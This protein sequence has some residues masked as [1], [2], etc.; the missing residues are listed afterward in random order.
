MWEIKRIQMGQQGGV[1][2]DVVYINFTMVRGRSYLKG[3]GRVGLV[4]CASS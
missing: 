2:V 4:S 3:G 1:M